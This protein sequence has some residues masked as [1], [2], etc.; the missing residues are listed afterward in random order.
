VEALLRL[1]SRVCL[2]MERLRRENSES[3]SI[4]VSVFVD[5]LRSP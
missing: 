3:G 2:R 5:L 4:K 1:F